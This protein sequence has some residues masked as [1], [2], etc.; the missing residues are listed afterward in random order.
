[1]SR[2]EML[3]NLAKQLIQQI[4]QGEVD[5]QKGTIQLLR[6]GYTYGTDP[7]EIE[8]WVP[9]GN[10]N[11]PQFLNNVLKAIFERMDGINDCEDSL[12]FI[13]INC[14]RENMTLQ[15]CQDFWKTIKKWYNNLLRMFSALDIEILIEYYRN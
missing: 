10:I 13:V 1:M 9:F 12:D 8:G 15:E 5:K 11:S 7:I 6:D 3:E 14:N 2:Q 4:S